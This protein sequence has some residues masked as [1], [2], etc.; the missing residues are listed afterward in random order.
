MIGVL[1]PYHVAAEHKLEQH[2]AKLIV[3]MFHLRPKLKIVT[4]KHAAVSS[5]FKLN[6]EE[7][8]STMKIGDHVD[9]LSRH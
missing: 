7:P 9:S 6:C 3:L 1:A 2:H 8:Q 5:L 4:H